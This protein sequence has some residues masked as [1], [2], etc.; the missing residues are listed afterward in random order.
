MNKTVAANISG[1]IF[2]IEENAYIKLGKYLDTIRG[3]F[4]KAEGDDEIMQDIEARIAELFQERTGEAKQVIN[5]KDVDEVMA[6]MGQPEDYFA[7]A[8]DDDEP[9][10]SKKRTSRS[11]GYKRIFRDPDDQWVGGVAAGIAKYFGFDPLILRIIWIISIIFGFGFLI[12]IIMWI[13]LPEAKTTAEKLQMEGE[14]VT[15]ENIKKRVEQEKDNVERGFKNFRN[16]LRDPENKFTNTIGDVFG[17][18]GQTLVL[19]LKALGKAM[20]FVLILAGIALL[21]GLCIMLF[22]TMPFWEMNGSGDFSAINWQ[23]LSDV[24]FISADQATL[25]MAGLLIVIGIPIVSLVY[26]GVAILFNAKAGVKGLGIALSTIWFVGIAMCVVIGIQIGSQFTSDIRL[27]ENF[28]LQQPKGDVLYLDILHDKYFSDHFEDHED[29]PF[30]LFKIEDDNLILG[31]PYLDVIESRTDSFEVEVRLHAHGKT[32]KSA[33]RN[34]EDIRYQIEQTDSLLRFQPFYSFPTENKFRG[35]HIK[36][37]VKVPVGKAVH[38]SKL[39]DRIIYDIDNVDGEWDGDM[40]GKTWTMTPQGL[41]DRAQ[42]GDVF[43]SRDNNE[44]EP[45]APEDIEEPDDDDAVDANSHGEERI[46]AYNIHFPLGM[47]QM[48]NGLL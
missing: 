26:A 19:I 12:Y 37:I 32:Q 21:V 16:D 45:E 5:M 28:A 46:Q 43:E 39:S 1:I 7:E 18:L 6:I 25:S 13:L 31:W 3:Y 15:V 23:T 38:L 8:D 40:V 29:R 41:S 22:G 27:K 30:E 17:F 47:W 24:F 35:Q 10:Q 20:G 34:A 42:P 33:I 44:D 14:P 9:V 48:L 11:K 2:N 4:Q 36:Y